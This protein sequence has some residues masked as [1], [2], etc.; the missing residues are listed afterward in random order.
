MEDNL[1]VL[2]RFNKNW[3]TNYGRQFKSISEIQKEMVHTLW[4]TIQEY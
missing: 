3:L 1:R 4:K 2:L